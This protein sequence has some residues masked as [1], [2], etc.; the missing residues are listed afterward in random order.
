LDKNCHTNECSSIKADPF[1]DLIIS[2]SHDSTVKVQKINSSSID[3]NREITNVFNNRMIIVMEIAIYHNIVIF[4]TDNCYV[5]I[6][7]YEFIKFIKSIKLK[8][9]V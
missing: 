5:C 4:G 7:D 3:F 1:N 2:S 6:C 9:D 8:D